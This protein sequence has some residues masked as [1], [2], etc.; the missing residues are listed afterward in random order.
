MAWS[1]SFLIGRNQQVLIENVKFS[2]QPVLSGVPQGTVLGPLYF[3]IYIN[4]ISHG[5]SPGTKIRLFADD[6]LLYR[7]IKSDH[8][9]S[10]LQKDLDHL[11]KWETTWK[12]EFHPQKCQILRITNKRKVTEGN[13]FIHNIPLQQT[14]TA[15]YLGIII[16][17]KLKWKD[18]YNTIIKKPTMC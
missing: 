18:Q 10:T 2:P 17:G 7:E 12:M 14:N 8:D 11:Q 3:L 13:Y 15:K 1:R 4:D 9:T 16:D 5:L 6:S